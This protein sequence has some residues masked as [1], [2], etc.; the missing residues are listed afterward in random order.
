MLSQTLRHYRVLLGGMFGYASLA[1][2]WRRPPRGM[3]IIFGQGRTGSSLLQQLLNCSP[4]VY[5]DNEVLTERVPWP[6]LTIRSLAARYPGRVYGCKVRCHSIVRQG[7][8]PGDFLWNFHHNGGR[9]I[10]LRRENIVLQSISRM[11]IAQIDRMRWDRLP[12]SVRRNK[13]FYIDCNALLQQLAW[14]ERQLVQEQQALAGLPHVSLVYE[15]HL[16]PPE[17][18]QGTLDTLFEYLDVRRVPVHVTL[19]RTSPERLVDVLE[20]FDEV[21]AV[22]A[23]SRYAPFLEQEMETS[24]GSSTGQAPAR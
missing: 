11:I 6:Y 5:C 15:Q 12:Y 17:M 19:A 7:I 14:R 23:G 24:R 3:F 1:A 9:I 21:A 22:I 13:R 4:E 8:P 20:N 2:F 10:Y 18:R 16:L